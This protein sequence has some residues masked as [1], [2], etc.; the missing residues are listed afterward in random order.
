MCGLFGVI[1]HTLS[2]NE[3]DRFAQLG[4]VSQ[5][6]GSHS[7]GLAIVKRKGGGKIKMQTI[8]RVAPTGALFEMPQ[9]W[10]LLN[11]K[12]LSCIM[13]HARHATSGHINERNSHPIL[14]GKILGMHN[15]TIEK[16]NKQV[17]KGDEDKLT[18]SRILFQNINKLGVIPTLNDVGEIGAF[19]L[20]F[21]DTS[22]QTLTLVRNYARELWIMKQKKHNC[23]YWASEPE[24]LDLVAARNKSMDFDAPTQLPTWV[25]WEFDLKSGSLVPQV[26]DLWKERQSQYRPFLPTTVPTLPLPKKPVGGTQLSTTQ[27]I[28]PL[29]MVYCKTCHKNKTYCYCEDDE[30]SGYFIPA[31]WQIS[32]DGKSYHPDGGDPGDPFEAGFQGNVYLGFEKRV[33]EID[34]AQQLINKEGCANCHRKSNVRFDKVW[35]IDHYDFLCDSCWADPSMKDLLTGQSVFLGKIKPYQEVRKK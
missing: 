1:S 16:Y 22:K 26:T 19:A 34:G 29:S 33:M 17:S 5:L 23:M 10:Q 11:E 6:R 21:F 18:D 13:G 32:S 7:S 20:T 15:G 28:K 27:S 30:T 24:M 35:W 3:I 2:A 14:E 9:V 12:D 25:M 31:E 8:N 4:I